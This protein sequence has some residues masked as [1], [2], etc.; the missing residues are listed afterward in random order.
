[1][2]QE[3]RSGANGSSVSRQNQDSECTARKFLD[4]IICLTDIQ[5]ASAIKG[6]IA[7]LEASILDLK[8]QHR[9]DQ[10]EI[11]KKH[12]DEVAAAESSCFQHDPFESPV[13]SV[14]S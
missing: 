11:A 12:A 5:E 9:Y 14:E 13:H 6:R 7:D 1:M 2:P 4:E 8:N 10:R 3:R